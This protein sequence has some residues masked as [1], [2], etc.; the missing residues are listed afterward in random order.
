MTY[1]NV[2]GGQ[3]PGHQTLEDRLD[4]GIESGP[5]SEVWP[6]QK[7]AHSGGQQQEERQEDE[8]VGNVGRGAAESG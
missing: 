7:V 3:V 8:K 6:H 5:H 2:H 1:E 4:G